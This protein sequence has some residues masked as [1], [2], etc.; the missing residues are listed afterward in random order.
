MGPQTKLL[1]TVQ[2]GNTLP[3]CFL[4][5]DG[6]LIA[7][8][9]YLCDPAEV[10]LLPGATEGLKLIAG[11][12]YLLIMVSNQS[13]IGRGFF[14]ASH[15]DLVNQ[16]MLNQL[17]EQGAVLDAMYYCPHAPDQGCPC[18]KP[19]PGMAHRA[20][21]DFSIDMQRSVMLG[22]GSPDI[23]FAQASG[24]PALIVGH[25]NTEPISKIANKP[26][27]TWWVK[28]L[29]GAASWLEGRDKGKQCFGI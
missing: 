24:L 21:Q 12:G 26:P 18:R 10:S 2:N 3:A 22:D 1:K 19:K 20:Q 11:L 14:E 25:S 15:A 9:H 8:K 16:E 5:R 29:I 17:A 27:D 7:D 13:G 6:T 28:D 4:D 23:G